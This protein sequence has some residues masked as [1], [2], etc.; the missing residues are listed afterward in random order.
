MTVWKLYIW[1]RLRT[2]LK[3]IYKQPIVTCMHYVYLHIHVKYNCNVCWHCHPFDKSDRE[4][5]TS[6]VRQK[7]LW[8]QSTLQTCIHLRR[9]SITGWHLQLCQRLHVVKT[10][11]IKSILIGNNSIKY[12]WKVYK[13][14]IRS[15]LLKNI[16]CMNLYGMTV[17]NDWNKGMSRSLISIHNV[18]IKPVRNRNALTISKLFLL[19][20]E[21][22][23]PWLFVDSDT[24]K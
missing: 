9:I 22:I 14:R 11:H 24:I 3:W 13:T 7:S 17:D 12:L 15:Y 2:H 18:E 19:L 6:R 20:L 16:N 23:L 8:L 10:K 4:T 5:D 1:R 21:L